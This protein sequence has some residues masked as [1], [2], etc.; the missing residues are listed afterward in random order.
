MTFTCISCYQGTKSHHEVSLFRIYRIERSVGL[1]YVCQKDCQ[2]QAPATRRQPHPV[3][4]KATPTKHTHK[5]T[6]IKH[7][8][9][10]CVLWVWPYFIDIHRF[11]SF[12]LLPTSIRFAQET[13]IQVGMA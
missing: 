5:A 3:L 6:P 2:A 11:F 13:I 1:V 7:I 8:Q 12:S 9:H 10:R 4:L